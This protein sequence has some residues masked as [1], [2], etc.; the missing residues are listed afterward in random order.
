VLLQEIGTSGWESGSSVLRSWWLVASMPRY[1]VVI[2][3]I[4]RGL[5]TPEVLCIARDAD[6]MELSCNRT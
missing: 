6:R 3:A 5:E 1:H 2:P 4:W